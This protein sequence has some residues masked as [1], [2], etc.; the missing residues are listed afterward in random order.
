MSHEEFL[1]CVIAVAAVAA[2]IDFFL[3]GPKGHPQ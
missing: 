3:N 2:L 1:A